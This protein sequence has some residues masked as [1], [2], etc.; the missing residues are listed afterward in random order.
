M[1]E[2]HPTAV[3]LTKTTLDD[4]IEVLGEALERLVQTHDFGFRGYGAA[5]QLLFEGGRYDEDLIE[6][7]LTQ[8]DFNTATV[9]RLAQRY[10]WFALEGS[11]RAPGA[12]RLCSVSAVLY[13]TF[14]GAF[15][16]CVVF[17]LDSWFLESVYGRDFNG[18][19]QEAADRL[20][21]LS[22]FLGAADRVDGFMTI[23]LP[24]LERVPVLDAEILR[25]LLLDPGVP[26]TSLEEALAAPRVGFIT[27]IRSSI[28]STSQLAA[29]WSGAKVIQTIHGFSVLDTMVHVPL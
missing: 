23:R 22:I 12:D 2:N 29:V 28:V 6:E 9:R 3:V 19:D 16:A 27:G 14:D 1:S 15:P 7:P 20:T 17:R 21:R 10:R 5:L 4:A 11:I 26:V 18:F 25:S 24:S 8:D 13:P